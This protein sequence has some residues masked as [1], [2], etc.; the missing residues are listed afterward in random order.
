VLHYVLTERDDTAFWGAC[1]TMT[2]PETLSDRIALFR[3]SG[4]AYQDGEEIFRVASWAQV[5]TGQR[6]S[7]R[8]HHRMGRIM[9][10]PRLRQVLGD[11]K[12][13][14]ARQVAVLP[15]HQDFLRTYCPADV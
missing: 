1:R 8:Q 2:I 3:E 6:L 5:M 14:I 13:N 11:M 7:P 10:K 15:T 4:M 9:G 12:T